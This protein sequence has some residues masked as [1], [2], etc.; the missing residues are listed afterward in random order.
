MHSEKQGK[1]H[2]HHHQVWTA[3][4]G[5]S[6]QKMM[7]WQ[8]LPFQYGFV[9]NRWCKAKNLILEKKPGVRKIHQL[10]IIGLL[11]ADFNTALK[12]IFG[13]KMMRNEET[14]GISEEQWGGRPNRTALDTACKKS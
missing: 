7:S 3:P 5:I 10:C 11:E 4:Y 2:H 14:S 13:R 8:S 12:L 9:N 6:L 1:T